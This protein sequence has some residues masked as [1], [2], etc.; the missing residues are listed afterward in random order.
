MMARLRT[1]L[2]EA[3]GGDGYECS[4]VWTVIDQMYK[5]CSLRIVIDGHESDEYVIKH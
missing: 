2:P 4:S 5:Q 3:E 1:K